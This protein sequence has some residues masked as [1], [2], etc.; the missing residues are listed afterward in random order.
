MKILLIINLITLLTAFSVFIDES[1]KNYFL[2]LVMIFSTIMTAR[3]FS[4]VNKKNLAFYLLPITLLISGLLHFQSFRA[5]SYLYGLSLILFYLGNLYLLKLSRLT[6]E[7]YKK[8]LKTIIYAYFI[9]L[10]IQQIQF[11]FG[12]DNFFNKISA[13]EYSFNVLATEPSYAA[14]IVIYLFYTYIK[15]QEF[16][17]RGSYSLN[18]FKKEKMLWFVFLYEMLTIGSAYG[19]LFLIIFLLTFLNIKYL[20]FVIIIPV[21]LFLI[22]YENNYLP[23][24]RIINTVTSINFNDKDYSD[25]ISADHSAAVRL[26]PFFIFLRDW[27]FFTFFGKGMDFSAELFPKLVIGVERGTKAGWFLPSFIIDYGVVNFLLIMMG[28]YINGIS[29]LFSL[30]S[31][32]LLFA[33]INTSFNTQLFWSIVTLLS[34]NKYLIGGSIQRKF[35]TPSSSM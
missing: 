10:I 21:F 30:G 23:L 18:V 1:G 13:R 20:W 19:I 16:L 17:C 7:Q 25:L 15:I 26:I 28:I 5:Y 29:R 6:I 27:E 4:N 9:V 12:Q 31:L 3:F 24:L 14:T 34:I 22:A 35:V 2:L 8:F 32:I 33:L 11:F